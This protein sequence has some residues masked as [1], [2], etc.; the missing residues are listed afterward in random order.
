[1]KSQ[2]VTTLLQQLEAELAPLR[3]AAAAAHEAAT[4][5]ESKPENQY[6]TR[7]LEASYLASAQKQRVSGLE[8]TIRTLRELP[9][10][11]GMPAVAPGAL[12]EAEESGQIR[13]FFFFPLAAGAVVEIQGKR[14]S[15]IGQ[16][17]PVG[18]ALLGK[19]AGDTVEITAGRESREYEIVSVD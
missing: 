12:V 10:R 2:L 1:M 11:T 6:D 18:R 16:E 14:V 17:S 7:A 8:F 3:L 15:V 13:W 9:L 5:E 4:S 19:A